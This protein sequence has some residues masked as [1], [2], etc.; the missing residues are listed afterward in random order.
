MSR[1]TVRAG[2][3][4]YLQPPAVAGLGN[5]FSTARQPATDSDL[6]GG[7]V[8]KSVAAGYL[9]IGNQR[10]KR[11]ALGGAHGGWKRRVYEVH[12]VIVFRSD[13][14]LADDVVGA[15]DDLLDALITRLEADRTWGGCVW[16]GGE[17]EAMGDNDLTVTVGWPDPTATHSWIASSIDTKAVEM[18]NS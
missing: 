8:G 10:E 9:H 4:A 7:L 16:Q 12:I 18:V 3:T 13:E 1:R 2:L 6:M 14:P 11:V 17:G 15:H 5:V